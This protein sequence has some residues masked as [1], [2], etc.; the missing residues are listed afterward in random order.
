V[1][2]DK[3][4]ML[5]KLLKDRTSIDKERAKR[6]KENAETKLAKLSKDDVEF[7]TIRIAMARAIMRISIAEKS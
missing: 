7:E 1:T 5:W 3:V 2:A 4:T 6:A